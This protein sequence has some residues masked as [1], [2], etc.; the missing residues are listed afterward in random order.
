MKIIVL[1]MIGLSIMMASFIKKG[2]TVT[3]PKT[4]LVWQDSSSVEGQEI[5]CG[6]IL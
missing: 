2:S 4:K 6:D 5:T 3:D 1:M